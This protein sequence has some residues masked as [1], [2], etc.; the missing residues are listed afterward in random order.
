MRWLSACPDRQELEQLLLGQLAE[1]E[2]NE[3][4]RHFELCE[5]CLRAARSQE[6]EDPLVT[7]V[8]ASRRVS[9][10]ADTEAPA[11]LI[12]RLCCLRSALLGIPAPNKCAV[13]ESVSPHDPRKSSELGRI[14]SYRVVRLLGSGAMGDVYL[15]LQQWPRREVALKIF[16]A[17]PRASGDRLGRFRAEVDVIARLGHPHIVRLY[18]VGEHDGR[19]YFTMEY[20]DG[21]NLAERLALAPMTARGAAQLLEPLARAVHAAHES[22]IIHRDLKPSNV[23]LTADGTPKVG[24]FGLAKQLEELPGGESP[25]CQTES[26]AIL[27]TP[28]YMAPEQAA[29]HTKEIGRTV[30]VYALGA[31]LY[32]ALTGRPPFQAA[33]VLETLEQVR[34][35]EPLS[36]RRLLPG[37]PRDLETI[38]LKSLE[39]EPTRRYTTALD[40]ADD[41]GRFHRG[42]PIRARPTGPFV[43]LQKWARRQ[44]AQ[45]GLV[46]VSCLALAGLVVGV[47]VHNAR[48]QTEVQ[49]AE[50]AEQRARANYQQARDTVS[51]MLERLDDRRWAKATQLYELKKEQTE[52]ALAFYKAIVLRDDEQDPAVQLDVATAYL[53]AG[54]IEY[55]TSRFD[56]ADKS[57]GQAQQQFERLAS[58]DRGNLDYQRSLARCWNHLGHLHT[59]RHGPGDNPLQCYQEALEIAEQMCGTHPEDPILRGYVLKVSQNVA[60]AL[61]AAGRLSEA[62]SQ[63]EKAVVLSRELVRDHPAT[64]DSQWNLASAL[65]NLGESHLA[66]GQATQ[67]EEAFQEAEALLERLHG[68][69]PENLTLA[70][71]LVETYGDRVWVMLGTARVPQAIELCTRAIGLAEE[72]QRREPLV[73]EIN[74]TLSRLCKVRA[75]AHGLARDETKATAD[76]AQAAAVAEKSPDVLARLHGALALAHLGDH[77]QAASRIA[78]AG[79]AD[80]LFQQALVYAACAGSA[81][82]DK[83]MPV[84]QR[85]Q[86]VERYADQALTLLRQAR[87]AGMLLNPA[88]QVLLRQGPSFS[89][90][91]QRTDFENL[92]RGL[93]EASPAAP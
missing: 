41:L 50:A 20:V 13:L 78:S 17:G 22:G 62:R 93:N 49:R 51:R 92:L 46:A 39:K 34:R 42:E 11:A 77:E 67:A 7:V 86:R 69:E 47:L 21:G 83:R 27:G 53:K 79:P 5:C 3:L 59:L 37:L 82:K 88:Y 48:L 24:D 71:N 45:A 89:A 81:G 38:C 56:D 60:N 32:E 14:G 33:S 6:P 73:M 40:L 9:A 80:Q 19:P 30:D 26:G 28:S 15:A 84:A 12:E 4:E 55:A 25:G 23:L 16:Q 10:C 35:Q 68:E 36:P 29:G 1:E 87:E 18:D 91:R 65:V 74:E 8:R 43:R 90:L 31:I 72:Y 44:P 64:S 70:S 61:F 85:A 52:D 54:L 75:L 57:L 2:V 63:R 58:A 76:W 66:D